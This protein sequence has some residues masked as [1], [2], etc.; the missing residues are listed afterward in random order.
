MLAAGDV[1]AARVAADELSQ[2][3]REVG[4]PLLVAMGARAEGAVLLAERNP[5]AGL[6]ALRRAFMAWQ[7]LDAPY[8]A[9][10]V[11]VLI[12]LACRALGDEET[13]VMELDAA[14]DVFRE[15]G[16][17]AEL[18]RVDVL[19]EKAVRSSGGLTARELEV[20][21]LVAT[22]KTNRAIAADLVISEKTVARYL[23]NI[24]TK[25]GLSSR[26][27]A[28]AHAYEHDLLSSRT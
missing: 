17:T 6:A 18:A 28:T 4:A 27:L 15:L 19:T 1:D 8:E 22:G 9:A 3:A 14:R 21:R 10:R 20:L 24:F 13:A 16:A 26:A 7:S 12:G 25:L 11:R 2:I 5:R 23:S